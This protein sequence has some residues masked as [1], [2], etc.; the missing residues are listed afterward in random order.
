MDDQFDR[1]SVSG[2]GQGAGT[3]ARMKEEI[4][5]KVSDAKEKVADFRRKAVDQIDSRR[6]P[7]ANTLDTT[8]SA[9]HQQGENAAD[10]AHATA[11]KLESTAD[12]LREHDVKAIMGDVKDIA[13]RYPGQCLAAA[14]LVGF[15]VGR[16]FRNTD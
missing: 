8:A 16:L 5:G 14:V 1:D 7:V 4:A 11:N 13:K 15:F 6:E 12:Y 2:Y 9:L 3:A 10:V